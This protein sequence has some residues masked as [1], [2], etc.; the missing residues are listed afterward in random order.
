MSFLSFLASFL[1]KSPFADNT[2]T[3]QTD[4]A[5]EDSAIMDQSEQ[6]P[7][8]AKLP[9]ELRHMVIKEAL[10]EHEE[11]TCRVVL[12]D[13]LTY[14]ISPTKE[15]AAM[16]SPLL[17]VNIEFRKRALKLY[18]KVG[19]F[20]LGAPVEDQYGRESSWYMVPLTSEYLNCSRQICDQIE[21]EAKAQTVQKVRS[22]AENSLAFFCGFVSDSD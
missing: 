13:P 7:L 9:T 22:P 19:V 8:F 1:P 16:A 6:F 4:E 5:N 3:N 18:T 21:E 17:F 12:F 15:L 14:R 20:D 11:E 2:Q 10:D